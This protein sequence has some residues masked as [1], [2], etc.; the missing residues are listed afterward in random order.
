MKLELD[1]Y[2][3]KIAIRKDHISWIVAKHPKTVSECLAMGNMNFNPVAAFGVRVGDAAMKLHDF[4][5]ELKRDASNGFRYPNTRSIVFFDELVGQTLAKFEKRNHYEFGDIIYIET[6]T[7]EQYLM[8][9]YQD[10][11][12]NVVLED[13]CGDISDLLNTPILKAEESTNKGTEQQFK[14]RGLH[15]SEGLTFTFYNI[16]TIKGFVTLR[17]V[18]TSNVYYSEKVD[19]LHL[20]PIPESAKHTCWCRIPSFE[21]K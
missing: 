21:N 2:G 10:C 6:T 8:Y 11:C 20:N 1:E 7:G 12:E 3:N 14:D 19:F 9:H 5:R 15:N 16:G 4:V 13:V 17:W 18:G